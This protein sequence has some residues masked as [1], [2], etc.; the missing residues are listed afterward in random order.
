MSSIVTDNPGNTQPGTTAAVGTD[1]QRLFYLHDLPDFKVHHDDTDV[2]GWKV[3]LTTGEVIGTVEN[4]IVDK[5]ARKVRYLEVTGDRSFFDG[6]DGDGYYLDNDSDRVFD[7]GHDEH[8]IVPI[9]MASLDHSDHE[10][11]VEGMTPDTVYGMPRY[12]K[13]SELRPRYEIDTVNY[14]SD[15]DSG[16]SFGQGY[17]RASYSDFDEHSYKGLDDGFYG[18][19]YFNKSRTYDRHQQAMRSS[20]L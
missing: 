3:K 14:L 2:R 18:S 8:V 5:A 20:G 4:L 7:A 12:R 15:N 10:I 16:T 9:G 19:G 11:Y 17:N 13:G 1:H 6:Y